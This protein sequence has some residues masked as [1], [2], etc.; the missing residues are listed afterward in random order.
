MKISVVQN[1]ITKVKADIIVNTANPYPIIGSGTDSAIYRAAG[2]ERLLKERLA[3]GNIQPGDARI[4]SGFGL[5][6]YIIHTV[7]P[8]YIDG[9]H[10]EEKILRSCYRNSLKLAMK[11][12]CA[13][14]VFPLI[15]SGVYGYP[16]EDAISV[17]VSEINDFLIRN[18]SDMKITIA[19]LNHDSFFLL[20]KIAENAESLIDPEEIKEILTRE[21]G[22]PSF[23]NRR[24]KPDEKKKDDDVFFSMSS[25]TKTFREMLDYYLYIRNEKPSTAYK[26]V[27]MD[28]RDFS[29]YYNEERKPHKR[30]AIKLC[31]GL[32]LTLNET[33]DLISRADHAFNPS[34]PEDLII[35]N[36]IRNSKTYV[37]IKDE[38]ER[39][40][41]NN[42]L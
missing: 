8:K 38:L 14:I 20:K 24:R 33:V 10:G 27:R 17:A 21:Y 30:D 19:V 6:R 23:H 18:V 29:K 42:T 32:R 5:C 25:E 15:S 28:R 16:I 31:I 7:G 39:N 3:I 12:Q 34:R 2:E 37:E 4:T 11:N 22:N 40:G 13:S 9:Q 41:F 36:G 26:R 1:D 35:I